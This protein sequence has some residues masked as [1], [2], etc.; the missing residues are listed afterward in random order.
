MKNENGYQQDLHNFHNMETLRMKGK[1][2]YDNIFIVIYTSKPVVIIEV[3]SLNSWLNI[4][5]IK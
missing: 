4:V 2:A 3:N 5:N 1:T